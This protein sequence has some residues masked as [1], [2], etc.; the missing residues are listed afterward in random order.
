MYKEELTNADSAIVSIRD[1]LTGNF[2]QP[3]FFK[4]KHWKE[5][6]Q[7]VFEYNINNIPIWKSNPSNFNMY[8]LGFFNEETGILFSNNELNMLF[9]GTSLVRKE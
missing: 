9:T 1:E 4:G 7:R 6:A 2:F 5:E 3:T 8:L